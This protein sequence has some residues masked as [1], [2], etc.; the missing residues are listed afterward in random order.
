MKGYKQFIS[1]MVAPYFIILV[2]FFLMIGPRFIGD[3][4]YIM[5]I[6]VFALM[7]ILYIAGGISTIILFIGNIKRKKN[8]I[9]L[10]R[11]NMIIKIVHILAYILIF[12]LGILFSIT[13]FTFAFTFLLIALDVLTIIQSGTV[14]VSGI[15]SCAREEIFSKKLAALYG[16]TQYIFCID[17]IVAVLLYVKIKREKVVT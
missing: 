13:I 6:I 2:F 4:S 15:I 7:V 5:F 16:F 10:I 17:V 14:G 3:T 12:I 9:E 1:L 8:G 11:I